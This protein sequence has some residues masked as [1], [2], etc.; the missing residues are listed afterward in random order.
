MDEQV[1]AIYENGILRPSTPL[2]LPEGAHVRVVIGRATDEADATGESPSPQ[3][4]LW[5]IADETPQPADAQ[6]WSSA[7]HDEL[8]YG[9]PDGPA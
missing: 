7:D 9:D 2:N 4:D 1:D 8:L 5:Q 3:S 6:Q